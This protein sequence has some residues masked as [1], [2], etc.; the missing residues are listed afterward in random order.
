MSVGGPVN[1]VAVGEVAPQP[2]DCGKRVALLREVPALA[3]LPPALLEYLAACL[4]EE[5]YAAASVVIAEGAA[6]DRL[7]V[8]VAGQAEVAAASQAGPVPL[9]TLGPGELFGELALL[10]PGAGRQAT[11]TA[12]TDLHLLTLEAAEFQ[13]LLES[14]PAARAAFDA[15]AELLLTARFLKLAS[16]FAALAPAQA[17]ALA[18]HLARQTVPA[19]TSVVR[20]GEVGDAAYLVQSGRVEVVLQADDGAEQRLATLRPGTI[21]GETA[22]LTQAPR[23]A[24]VRALE[25]CQ[26]LVLHRDDLLAVMG[27][28]SAVGVRMLELLQLRARPRQVAGIL[29]HERTTPEGETIRILKDP[30]RGRYYRLSPQGWFLWQRLDGQ[31]TLRHLAL[32]YFDEYKSFAPQAIAQVLGGLAAAGFIATPELPADVLQRALHVAWWQRALL[33][34]R[35]VATW[36]VALTGLDP[37]LARLYQGGIRLLYTRPAQAALLLLIVAGLVAFFSGSARVSEALAAAGPALLLFL[38]PAYLVAIVVHEAGHAF[39]VKAFGR[40]VQRGGVGWYWFGPIAFIDTSDMWLADRW[41][42]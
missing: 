8:V 10:E 3:T 14:Q 4:G 7:F 17:R 16:L 20:Q 29:V 21:F 34:A 18:A 39:T 38:I 5:R 31:R 36:Q 42:R 27:V 1:M 30:A 15:A 24:T 33:A 23:N 13:A 19:G 2:V 22:L 37:L 9:A 26:L 12:L 6:G 41:P 28:E 11:V 32:D 25:P 40:E 35:Q